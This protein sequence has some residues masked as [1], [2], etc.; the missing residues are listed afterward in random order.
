M[1]AKCSSYKLIHITTSGEYKTPLVASQLFDQAETQA[2]AQGDFSPTKVFVWCI[3]PMR[4]VFKNTSINYLRGL[5]RRCPNVSIH[6][7]TGINRL[8]NFPIIPLLILKRFLLGK[9]KVVIYH[10]RGTGALEWAVRLK[11]YF[12]KDKVVLDIR[13]YWPAELLYNR[14]VFDPLVAHGKDLDDYKKNCNDLKKAIMASDGVTTITEELKT[15][16]LEMFNVPKRIWVV[17]CCISEITVDSAREDVRKRWGVNKDEFLVVYSGT[18][19]KYQHLEDLTLPFLNKLT[20]INPKIKLL[21]LTPEL[22]K[23]TKLVSA[24]GI[25]LEKVIIETIPQ[26]EVGKYLTG[27]DAGILIRLPSL[28]NRVANPVKIGEYLGSGLGVIIESN[29][30][31]ISDLYNESA[32]RVINV[33]DAHCDLIQQAKLANNWILENNIQRRENARLLAKN[34]FLWQTTIKIHRINYNLILNS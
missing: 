7:I 34:K 3:E 11:R 6:L 18:T 9:N 21:F 12:K 16:L 33:S 13:G 10:C 4:E 26:K 30:G 8:K 17:P 20:E 28:V 29:V 1:G 32:I 5:R 22:E 2:K 31:G 25:S 24:S 15:L 27:A 23:M 19:A 14:N